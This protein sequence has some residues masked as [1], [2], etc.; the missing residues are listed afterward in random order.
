MSS[1][2]M[3]SIAAERPMPGLKGPLSISLAMH[4]ALA[5]LGLISLYYSRRGD[6]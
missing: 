5:A 6:S 2:Q 3:S 1:I 4:F